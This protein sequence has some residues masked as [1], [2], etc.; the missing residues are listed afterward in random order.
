[1]FSEVDIAAQ[2]LTV[3]TV[4]SVAGST[5]STAKVIVFSHKK[6]KDDG[7]DRKLQYYALLSL[8]SVI[9]FLTTRQQDELT[10]KDKLVASLGR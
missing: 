7:M 8:L 4:L 9:P 10:V 5:Q 6:P 2:Y 3:K 1:L